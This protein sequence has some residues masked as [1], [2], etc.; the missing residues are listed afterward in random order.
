MWGA[1][2]SW[3]L[4]RLSGEGAI[5]K[6]LSFSFFFV[7]ALAP[8]LSLSLSLSPQLSLLHYSLS[9][10]DF[11]PVSCTPWKNGMNKSD[12]VARMHLLTKKSISF[13][14]QTFLELLFTLLVI[15]VYSITEPKNSLA[16]FPGCNYWCFG[17][18]KYIC[19][20]FLTPN[21]QKWLARYL[22][23]RMNS[24]TKTNAHFLFFVS[25]AVCCA[26]K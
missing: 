2:P 12:I 10:V 24:Q 3:G 18:C 9:F 1:A 16:F 22:L 23:E 26:R 4:L 17:N 13:W 11:C 19:S 5:Q 8:S 14:I 6:D 7:F 15:S 25:M 21:R 20:F